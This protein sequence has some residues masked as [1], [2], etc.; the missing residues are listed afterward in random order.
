MVFITR[1]D[2]NISPYCVVLTVPD[3]KY[4]DVPGLLD[5]DSMVVVLLGTGHYTYPKL[6]DSNM[7][8]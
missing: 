2:Q 3:I 4:V 5:Q 6:K 8:A 7:F 1:S